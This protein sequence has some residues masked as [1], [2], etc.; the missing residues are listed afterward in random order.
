MASM[1]PDTVALYC[2]GGSTT[3][4]FCRG[5]HSKIGFRVAQRVVRQEE[6]RV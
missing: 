2:C 1:A 3:K 4:P 6:E 5:T